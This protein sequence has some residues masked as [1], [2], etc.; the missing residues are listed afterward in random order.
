MRIERFLL[1]CVLCAAIGFP[2]LHAESPFEIEE[3]VVLVDDLLV[4]VGD[5]V[6]GVLLRQVLRGERD[7]GV[8]ILRCDGG[9]SQG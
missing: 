2:G 3:I 8:D 5:Y 6:D 4:D 7:V 1:S 9:Q